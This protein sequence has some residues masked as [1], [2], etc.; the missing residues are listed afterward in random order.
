MKWLV[1]LLLSTAF[2]SVVPCA[3][4]RSVPLQTSDDPVGDA[5]DTTGNA[6]GDVSGSLGDPTE[7]LTETTSTT[8]QTSTDAVDSGT[9]SGG[10]SA[11]TASPGKAL[12]TRFDRLPPRLERLLERIEL[13][14]N[15]RANLRRL[16]QAL[17][18]ASVRER[19]RLLRRLNAE[20]RRLRA[21]GV[22]PAERKQIDRLIRT[23]ERITALSGPTSTSGVAVGTTGASTTAPALG[24]RGRV[25]SATG[26]LR[27]FVAGRKET[28]RE[29]AT[30]PRDGAVGPPGP[31]R[32]PDEG[33]EGGFPLAVV[34]LALCVLLLLIVGGLAIKEERAA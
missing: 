21:D 23:R 6:V 31:S 11:S 14:R 12:R 4:A 33:A 9:T 18:S 10:T 32:V 28:P 27:A 19:A 25:S 13:G 30:S 29:G 7:G 20:I 15:V 16:E 1:S 17:R 5:V 2:A 3:G 26:V 8:E 22:S 34:L 24:T